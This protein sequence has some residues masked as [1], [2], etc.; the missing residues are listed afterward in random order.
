MVISHVYNNQLFDIS[1]SNL[2]NLKQ[3][4]FTFAF[5]FPNFN[6]DCNFDDKHVLLLV[7]QDLLHTKCISRHKF[8]AEILGNFS[9]FHMGNE[10]CFFPHLFT[11]FKWG[12]SWPLE[13]TPSLLQTPNLGWS[14][15]YAWMDHCPVWK[16]NNIQAL[17]SS[18]IS[19][20]FL[21]YQTTAM[22]HPRQGVLF[23]IHFTL[24][25]LLSCFPSL[26]KS[27]LFSCLWV[28]VMARIMND[29]QT[30]C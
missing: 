8:L 14:V 29:S 25:S 22:F 26:P 3:E 30:L 10:F 12:S 16:S 1:Q 2:Q 27:Q 24:S 5:V 21:L 11:V 6:T 9:P 17:F 15:R 20:H 23:T 18:Q 4:I 7:E 13:N 19:L 28:S